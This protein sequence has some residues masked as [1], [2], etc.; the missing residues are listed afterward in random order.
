MNAHA[1]APFIATLAYIPLL[2]TTISSRPWHKRHLLF[3][4]FLAAAMLWSFD[5]YLERAFIF[6]DHGPILWKFTVI[7]FSFTAVQ[8]HAFMSSYY[9]EG[10]KRWLV[11]SY[12]SMGF[13]IIAV[14]LGWVIKDTFI[15]GQYVSSNY[16]E[17]L[18]LVATPILVLTTRNFYVFGKLYKRSDDPV[19]RNHAF[20]FLISVSILLSFVL[21][22]LPTRFNDF[23]FAHYGNL[24]NAFILSYAVVRH[25]LVDIKI[26]L[27][28]GTTWASLMVIGVVSFWILLVLFQDLL[29]LRFD[30]M[31]SLVATLVALTVSAGIYIMREPFFGF[32]TRAFQGSSYNYRQQLTRFINKIHS[33][34]SLKEQGGEL[35][36]L[37]VK[38][39]NVKEACL[40]FPEPGSDD[41]YAQFVEPQGDGTALKGL[42]LRAGNPIIRYLAKEQVLLARE[43]L[44]VLPA[45]LGLWPQER[46]ELE[47]KEI[48]VFMPLISRDHLIA[49]LVLG[50]KQSGRYSLEDYNII[51]DVTGRVAVSMEK[52]YLADQLRE[53]EEE[54][55]VINNSSV[56]LTSSL[57]I[58][59]IFGAFT[60]ELKKVVDVS[61]SSI[62]LQEETGLHCAALSSAE[63]SAYQV[64]E[65]IPVEGTGTGWVITQKKSFIEPDLAQERYFN[66]GG[67]FYK[68]GLRTV[69]YL[70]LIAKG[71]AIG[72]FIV[73][74]QRPHAYSQRQIKLLE[75]LAAQIAMP[76]EN[77][78]L[79]ARA[80]KK[81]RVDE[82]TR[83][84]NRRSLDEMIDSEIS[85]HSRYGGVFSLAILDLDSFKAYNDTYGHLSGDRLLTDVGSCISSTIRTSDSAFRYGGDEFAILL[86]H[87]NIE[88]AYH[89][90]ERVRKKICERVNCGDMAVSAS[91]GLAS[92]PDHGISH[93]DIIAAADATLYQAKRNGGNQSQCA[94]G[95]LVAAPHDDGH[96]EA[97][98]F[99]TDIVGMARALSETADARCSS[100]KDRSQNIVEDCL[101]MARALQLDGA[102]TGRLEVCALL[103]DIGKMNI[104]DDILTKPGSLTAEEWEVIKTHPMLGAEVANRIPKLATCVGG[105]LHHHER[106][107]GTGYP[108]GLKGEDIP[109]EAR[110]LA[111]ADAFTAMTS[112]R[113]YSKTLSFGQGLEEIER[114]AGTQFD[115]ALVSHFLSLHTTG[116][117]S[118]RKLRR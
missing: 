88:A 73:A 33:V 55:S 86:P 87:T 31:S 52:E 35:L 115:P 4:L 11:F 92:W 82:L 60:E 74:S 23:P 113:P 5:D 70:P 26:V 38:S 2:I 75:Q 16:R 29:R 103:H 39:I 10:E 69:S 116:S 43:S 107:D 72:S 45:F 118:T 110:I 41:F 62:V 61:W 30:L 20:T 50:K 78:Q 99:D 112:E 108:D 98:D 77:A 94:T 19:L 105:I 67:V 93:T 58:P 32:V 36:S 21:I 100:N 44:A 56:I 28:K 40:L 15:G 68:L 91:I 97:E 59:G 117:E 54:L 80:E 79:Y 46:E 89:V 71:R 47:A 18:I 9:P 17:G 42:R 12:V 76:L 53:R 64:G 65:R 85:R 14:F 104:S 102:T 51:E 106:Y 81:A 1:I 114:C 111:I 24:L 101:A 25:K 22:S 90:T 84:Y 3:V 63:G 13:I 96:K 6:R 83:L 109:L 34:F 27:R 8:F 7:L 57:D 37:L 48:S 95:E 49:I 66:T